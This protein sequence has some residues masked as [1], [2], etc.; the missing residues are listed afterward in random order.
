LLEFCFSQLAQRLVAL[1]TARTLSASVQSHR[2]TAARVQCERGIRFDSLLRRQFQAVAL[3]DH[4]DNKH[5][6]HQPETTA[7]AGGPAPN[8]R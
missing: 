4:G 8:G 5:D 1:S 7:K 2:K 3:G 6:F